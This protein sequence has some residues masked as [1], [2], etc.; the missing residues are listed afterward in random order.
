M[1]L[2]A[3]IAKFSR[4]A[5]V[6]PDGNLPPQEGEIYYT[7]WYGVRTVSFR[8]FFEARQ[9]GQRV[10]TVI[11][12]LQPLPEYMMQADDTCI[13]SDKHRYKIVQIQPTRDDDAGE[14]A[15]DLTL[16][17]MDGIWP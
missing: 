9:A 16:E 4:A 13:L 15:L 14:D 5:S 7:A 17:R 3:G 8:R 12:V 6:A 10:D 2:D 11:R 1:I